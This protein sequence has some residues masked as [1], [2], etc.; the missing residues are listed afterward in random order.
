MELKLDLHIHTKY[1]YDSWNEIKDIIK[2]AKEKG[3]DGIGLVDHDT[4][5]GFNEMKRL[6]KE[7]SI[8]II[9][10]AEVRV[11]GGYLLAYGDINELPQKGECPEEAVTILKKQNV[12][13]AAVSP[14]K[15]GMGLKNKVYSLKLDAI[16]TTNGGALFGDKKSE[17]IAKE[18]KLPQI[19]GSDA[20]FL[21][22]IGDVF[23]I[24]KSESKESEDIIKSIKEGN[25]VIIQDKDFIKIIMS[26]I[27]KLINKITKAK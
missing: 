8:I 22:E 26:N 2:V 17:R 5:D 7:Q 4:T 3:L 18:L 25:S 16:E 11:K 14:F 21:N 1:S 12:L 15:N 9:P 20:H 6:G 19:G 13:I 23:T 10:G 24:V 27:K